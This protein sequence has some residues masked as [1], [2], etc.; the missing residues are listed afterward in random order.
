MSMRTRFLIVIFLTI[1][2]SA[3]LTFLAFQTKKKLEIM[4]NETTLLEKRVTALTLLRAALRQSLLD[5]TQFLYSR[6]PSESKLHQ[7]AISEMVLFMS[8]IAVIFT[9]FIILLLSFAGAFILKRLKSLTKAMDNFDLGKAFQNLFELNDKDEI[10]KIS[11][12]FAALVKR[13]L[14]TEQLLF[15]KKSKS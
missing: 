9:L 11:V 7:S 1:S 5:Y 4:A 3:F 12:N 10:A 15:E 8:R 2:F 13:I 6:R 14:K